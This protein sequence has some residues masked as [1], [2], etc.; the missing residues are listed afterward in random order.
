MTAALIQRL[1]QMAATLLVMSFIAYIL[2]GL[3]PGDPVD[4]MLA[5]NPH[6]TPDDAARLKALYGLDRPLLERYVHWL[7]STFRGEAGYSRLF[8][9]PVIDVLLPRLLNTAI[10]ML[11]SLLLTVGVAVP[12]GVYAARRP[13]SA[14]DRFINIFCLAGLSMPAFWLAL[15]LMSLF[16]VKLHVL[17][18][19]ASLGNPASLVLPI[20]TIA[21]G[22]LAGYAR[23]MRSAMMEA[24]TA[25]H[26]RTARAK[27]CSETQVTWKHAFRNALPPAVTLLMLDLGTMLSGAV[28]VE[29]IFAYPG[30][31]KLMFDAVMGNDF[32]LALAG[33]L[34]LTAVVLACNLM[35]D[36]LYARLDPRPD[37]T[38]G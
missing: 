19:S 12:L 23:H 6:L 36:V 5:G 15:L 11:A 35:A 7:L 17:P 22:G 27:G 26:I 8:N 10:L 20:I 37:K 16:V 2:I 4:L 33:F 1:F 34:L 38:A 9:L 25:D 14:F 3:M 24:L 29:T 13:G 30:M 18:A 28:T 31:G 32:N 21:M